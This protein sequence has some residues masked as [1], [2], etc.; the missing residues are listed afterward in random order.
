MTLVVRVETRGDMFKFEKIGDT[1]KGHYQ[2]SK[3]EEGKYG[4]TVKHLF[5]TTSGLKVVFGN[6]QLVDRLPLEKLGVYM[7]ITFTGTQ[8]GKKGNPMKL[9]QI[10]VDDDNIAEVVTEDSYGPFDD[11][12]ND[13]DGENDAE[14]EAIA[15]A[16][17]APTRPAAR[18]T[19][20]NQAKVAALLNRNKTA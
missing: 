8:P 9:F 6:K 19:A 12:A 11:S 10:A 15:P 14:V 2:G 20:A 3:P 5:K 4:P 16:P 7:E 18:P 1:L 17:V 13:F